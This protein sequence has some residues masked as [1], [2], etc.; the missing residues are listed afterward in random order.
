MT[1]LASNFPANLMPMVDR[2]TP[3]DRKDIDWI[4]D[5]AVAWSEGMPA[6][7]FARVGQIVSPHSNRESTAYSRWV[8]VLTAR[9]DPRRR[10]LLRAIDEL[11]RMQGF[12]MTTHGLFDTQALYEVGATVRVHP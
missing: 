8:A 3:L 6:E 5:A 2:L 12:V 7:E 4:L 11:I 9:H 10:H 1:W